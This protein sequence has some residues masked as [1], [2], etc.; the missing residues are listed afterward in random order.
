MRHV[1][2]LLPRKRDALRFALWTTGAALVALLASAALGIDHPWWAAM[3]VW[4]VAQ[5]TRGLLLERILARMTGTVI[6]AGAGSAILIV[7]G[8]DWYA[9]LALLTLWL[10]LCAAGGSLARHFRTYAFVLSGYSAAI[11]VLF[12]LGAVG[13]GGD[14]SGDRIL[15]TLIGIVC[16]TVAAFRLPVPAKGASIQDRLDA[17]IGRVLDHVVAGTGGTD[18]LLADVVALERQADDVAAGSVQERAAARRARRA[19]GVLVELLALSPACGARSPRP[20]STAGDGIERATYH[21]AAAGREDIV[22]ALDELRSRMSNPPGGLAWRDRLAAIDW[23]RVAH[24]GL[25]PAI[26]LTI[27]AT[28]WWVSGWR[29]GAMMAMAAALFASVFSS[30]KQGNRALGYALVGAL[31]GVS[32]GAAYHVVVLPGHASAA[33]VAVLILPV[34]LA[35]ACLMRHPI[36]AA[37]A[38]DLNMTFLLTAQPLAPEAS[39]STAAALHMSAAIIAG[40]SIAVLTYR[41]ILPASMTT[42]ATQLQRRAARLYGA[43]RTA[44]DIRTARRVKLAL[45]ATI[46]RQLDV[47]DPDAALAVLIRPLAPPDRG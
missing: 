26:A 5:P 21:A 38:I 43:L 46:L 31:I 45:R 9:T 14:V 19:M 7:A 40:L 22:A 6:G 20:V 2:N 23:R 39:S 35:G 30:H 13:T 3:T 16:A 29:E 18:A 8:G 15:C 36:T 1:G 17:L 32:L 4:L 34:L 37:L 28:L 41:L 25:R 10:A 33:V 11:V 27:A 47:A 42:S 12:R 44:P 24:A